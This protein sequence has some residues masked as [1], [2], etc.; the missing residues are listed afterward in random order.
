MAKLKTHVMGNLK[1]KIGNVTARTVDG[2]TAFSA[3]PLNYHVSQSEASINARS[4]FKVTSEL[5][6]S[7]L[8]LPDMGRI[9]SKLKP[10]GK[11][12]RSLLIKENYHFS[13]IDKPTA[14]N[15][16]GPEGFALPFQSVVLN[17][18]SLD[19]ELNALNTSA[20]FSPEEVDLGISCLIS[21]FNPVLEDEENFKIISLT[22]TEAGFD[23]TSAYTGALPLNFTHQSIAAKYQNYII[24]LAATSK[25]SVGDIIQCSSTYSSET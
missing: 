10:S 14:R 6:A 2:G 4:R 19:L 25:N 13:G 15:I 23:F 24:F 22:K 21:F 18:G 9:W 5:A 12:A 11:S 7:I 1:G 8:S 3:R 20:D 17:S 16:I